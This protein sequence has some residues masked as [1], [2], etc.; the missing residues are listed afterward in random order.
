MDNTR[1][2]QLISRKNT[3][4]VYIA[5]AMA[6]MAALFIILLGLWALGF[7]GLIVGFFAIYGVLFMFKSTEV[8]Y[9]YLL[10]NNEL[11]IDVVY[12]KER[13]KHLVSYDVREAEIFAPIESDR[14]HN[15]L[16]NDKIIGKNFTSGTGEAKVYTLV[17]NSN[18]NMYKVFIEPNEKLFEGIRSYIPR[19]TYTE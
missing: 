16:H 3:A 7:L 14:V 19:K 8:E 4:I 12:G 2:E 10:V 9:E 5:R 18:A 17:I 6:V 13:R 15:Y 11:S 1:V